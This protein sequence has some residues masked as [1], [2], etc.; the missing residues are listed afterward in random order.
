M[1]L[2]FYKLSIKS[3]VEFS[4]RGDTCELEREAVYDLSF[5]S[6]KIT[7]LDVIDY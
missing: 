3:F 7:I 1:K 2:E 5:I 4:I 6:D